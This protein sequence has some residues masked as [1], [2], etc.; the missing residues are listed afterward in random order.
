MKRP[1]TFPLCQ[2]NCHRGIMSGHF[3]CAKHLFACI[4]YL[5][6]RFRP[7]PQKWKYIQYQRQPY[8]WRSWKSHVQLTYL[9]NTKW[10]HLNNAAGTDYF[11]TDKLPTTGIVLSLLSRSHP[12][13]SS[14]TVHRDSAGWRHYRPD[15]TGYCPWAA[16]TLAA[17]VISD[18]M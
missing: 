1:I 4:L 9:T 7:L 6:Y 5:G 11:R 17:P 8:K 15:D 10:E 16:G 3:M 18:W 13:I 14:A 12:F 2:S